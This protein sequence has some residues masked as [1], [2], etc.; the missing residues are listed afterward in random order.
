VTALADVAHLGAMSL[1]LG[2]LVTLF[3]YLLRQAST[4]ELTAIL[5]VWSRWAE[6]AV[7]V[8]VL[9]GT[10]QALVEVGT[11][12]GLFGTS[13]GR[14]VLVKIGL[15][16]AIV[17][18]ASYSR[19]L[20]RVPD[21]G[22]V[23]VSRGRLRRTVVVELAIAVVVLGVAAG[24]AQTTPARTATASAPVQPDFFTTTLNSPLYSLQLDVDPARTGDN[25]I[26]LTATT[27]QGAPAKVLEW[28]VTA[29]LPAQGIEPVTVPVLKITDDHAV[30]QARFPTPG[31]WELRFT[32]RTSEIDE[33]TVTVTVQVR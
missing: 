8:L 14:L 21:P 5:P 20:A 32:L 29:A 28:R 22:T 11:L 25:S 33:A 27:P 12:R 30:G 23:K 13:Y 15:L 31:A 10:V 16:V 3:A 1:W 18:V 9:A 24:L 19:R 4:R 2:G 7:A 17:A 6:R 26:H